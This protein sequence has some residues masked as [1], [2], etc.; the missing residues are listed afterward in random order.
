MAGDEV[1][2]L[3]LTDNQKHTGILGFGHTDFFLPRNIPILGKYNDYGSLETWE[4]GTILESMLSLLAQD[5]ISR[6]PNE[7]E[8][9]CS[10]SHPDVSALSME[11]LLIW[12]KEGQVKIDA[13]FIQRL[14]YDEDEKRDRRIPGYIKEPIPAQKVTSLSQVL[15]RKDVWD[16]LCN[17]PFPTWEN[18]DY[19]I[20]NL[21]NEVDA[22]LRSLVAITTDLHHA[23]LKVSLYKI[24]SDFVE[25]SLLQ[26]LC[27]MDADF[28]RTVGIENQLLAI[29]QLFKNKKIALP[30]ITDI[31]NRVVEY[32]YV[33]NLLRSMRF[34]WHLP[35]GNG[36]QLTEFST[37]RRF[38]EKCA[39]IADTLD[40]E[41]HQD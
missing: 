16:M 22:L 38:N 12:L 19:T 5:I 7:R 11:E 36:S 23:S 6:E 29:M 27:Y 4:T 28:Y 26:Q 18:P 31:L 41:Y 2:W 3:M 13:N 37:Y 8:K 40:K 30:D 21:K 20:K 9:V 1:L 33:S 34:A 14:N 10:I 35:S 25:E 32:T 17:L 15:I 24:P 39:E